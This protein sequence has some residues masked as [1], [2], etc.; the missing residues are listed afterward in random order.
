MGSCTWYPAMT[1]GMHNMTTRITTL[2]AGGL[3]ALVFSPLRADEPT[4]PPDWPQFRGVR[5][6]GVSDGYT[7]PVRWDV[8]TGQEIA[9]QTRIPGMGHAC[10]IITG[11]RVF[12]VTAVSGRSDAG[13][14]IGLYGDIASVNDSTEHTWHLF[15]LERGSGKVLWQ[16]LLHK[17]VPR[18]KRH[19]KATHANATPVTDGRRVVVSLGSEGLYCFDLAGKPL[20]KQDLGLLDS[21]YFRYP[22]A[23]WG[24]ASS[25][26]LFRDTVIVQCDIQKG[27][28][29]A[30]F[31]LADG[32]QL[33]KTARNEVP[34]WSTPTIFE[35][36]G[37]SELI[38]SGYR[39]SGGYNP[40][41]GKE[42]WK[43]AGGGDI[44]VCTPVIADDL[45]ILSS[46]HGDSR[47]L[48]AI[49]FG[50]QGDITP[51]KSPTNGQASP[52]PIAWSLPRDG[53]YMQTPLVYGDHLYA[54][55]NNGVLSCYETRTGRR[56]YR[57]R[58]DGGV[59]FTASAV[60]GDGKLYFTSE[61]G[62]IHVVQA[63]PTFRV[64]A[65]NS[66]NEICMATPAI[67]GG[68]LIVRGRDH[69]HAIGTACFPDRP[70]ATA[71]P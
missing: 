23:Q 38:I 70:A 3:L 61:D 67:S 36:P 31:R 64:L 55:R 54:C 53:I 46:A 60:A 19:T 59:A 9:W 57:Q 30:A 15:C 5:A 16:H 49:R 62:K 6:C 22:A 4:V 47:P 50:S 65:T 44:P 34:T 28:Y 48:R 24:F 14:K 58:L 33:W 45:V 52:D 21:G 37:H 2:V 12:I 1:T 8:D 29:L 7:L 71:A 26:I 17:G 11:N 27:S 10:P 25:P 42:L 20:W 35:R 43:L 51:G 39:H 63:G 41:T 40:L 13:L 18:T 66:V 68:L 56:V 69:V 32:H